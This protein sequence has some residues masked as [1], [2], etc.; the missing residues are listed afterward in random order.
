MF[1]GHSVFLTRLL[2]GKTIGWGGQTRDDHAVPWSLAWQKLWP[3]TL[4]GWASIAA[5]AAT[6]PV[7]IPYALFI[8]GGLALA[9]PIAVI[10]ASPGFGRK[11]MRLGLGRLPEETQSAGVL[12]TLAL[13][14]LTRRNA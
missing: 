4:L 13:P 2:L 7:A 8:A 1:F 3:Q 11:L 6:H 12:R 10:T 14:A 9:I 5:L